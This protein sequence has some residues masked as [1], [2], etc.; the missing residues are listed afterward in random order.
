[1]KAIRNPNQFETVRS[2]FDL[3]DSL[4][5]H[6]NKF[7]DFVEAVREQIENA[8]DYGATWILVWMFRD[9]EGRRCLR[10]V[11]DGSGMSCA[12][13]EAGASV[14]RS[15]SKNDAAKRGNNGIG[16]KAGLRHAGRVAIESKT[17]TE[18]LKRFSYDADE[19][20][21]HTR[22]G[23]AGWENAE[24]RPGHLIRTTGTVITWEGLGEGDPKLVNPKHRRTT[25]R[26]IAELARKLLPTVAE[27]VRVKDEKGETFPLKKREMAGDP[28]ILDA[29]DIPS[30]GDVNGTI[31]VLPEVENMEKEFLSI[32]AFGDICSWR[33]FIG[34]LDH[35]DRYEALLK[36]IR[37][38]LGNPHVIGWI[39]VP[40]FKRYKDGSSNNFEPALY[41]DEDALLAL[42]KWLR[43]EIVPKV[44][45]LLGKKADELVTDD[46][47]TFKDEILRAFSWD[48][49]TKNE[50]V[51]VP[52][53]PDVSPRY[54]D[55][56]PG[57]TR[58][59]EVQGPIEGVRY[60]WDPSD[61]GGT[62]ERN[63]LIGTRVTYTAGRELGSKTL[64]V[65]EM[66]DASK[67]PTSIAIEIVEEL[68]F[69]CSAQNLHVG[70]HE[71]RSLHLENTRHTSGTF[72]WVDD[73]CG[74]TLTVDP[75]GTKARYV[76]GVTPGSDFSITVVDAKNERYRATISIQVE[77][78]GRNRLRPTI[79]NV[80]IVNGR[81]YE[82]EFFDMKTK[83][84]ASQ[85]HA[86]GPTTM[87]VLNKAHPMFARDSLSLRLEAA[88]GQ[89]T[90]R[91]AEQE[92]E[93]SPTS[94]DELYNLAAR[95]WAERVKKS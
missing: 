2:T 11:D 10:I 24:L 54:C 42:F 63:Q 4:I 87:I 92:L 43:L 61:S 64:T 26:L 45:A 17:A 93:G 9:P 91:I 76:A 57:Q 59:F 81:S 48:K 35:D 70:F 40:R 94:P 72:R 14:L 67:P 95:I 34:E 80:N 21:A 90:L 77:K 82:F 23:T 32:G 30:L 33:T 12:G 5:L 84:W 75:D 20:L 39:N 88:M 8:Q 22:A 38:V 16:Q 56:E 6:T 28:I 1:M 85:R 62:L 49:T 25:G 44:E 3:R 73:R 89:I 51:Q 31:Y 7:T 58:V 46:D 79:R 68:P 66:G 55:I 65:R 78:G 83:A 13:R 19:L 86:N 29:H 27:K 71:V 41:D 52:E 36:P 69:R 53:G 47:Q 15:E 60:A 50:V 37:A 18:G 74:G